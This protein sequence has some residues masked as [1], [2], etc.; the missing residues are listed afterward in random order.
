VAQRLVGEPGKYD[1]IN[2]VA[3]P[4]VSQAELAKRLSAE[5]PPGTEAIIGKAI[6]PT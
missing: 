4:G 6:M 5:V 2:F 3:K 1:Q